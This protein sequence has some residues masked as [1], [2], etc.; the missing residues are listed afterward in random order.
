MG[1]VIRIGGGLPH[2]ERDQRSRTGR[3]NRG[4]VKS[5][6]R[7][8]RREAE[9]QVN[10]TLEELGI[11]KF[12]KE[13]RRLRKMA[14]AENEDFSAHK[15]AYALL[16]AQLAMTISALPVLEE[17]LHKWKNEKAAYALVSLSA[18]M[19]EL[20]HDLRAFGD[21]TE[22]FSRIRDVVVQT[23]MRELA[24]SIVQDLIKARQ[25]IH[26]KLDRKSAAE[27]EDRL[28][29]VQESLA[30]HFG[31]AESEAARVLASVLNVK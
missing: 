16:R 7:D 8:R 27:V 3:S 23:I 10:S 24:A 13:F 2:R 15:T 21:Q 9:A 31:K 17:N 22:T 18:H 12:D 25:D 20:Q 29:V 5:D 26:G 6:P 1:D 14:T 28:R 30:S 11:Q 4:K 19:R